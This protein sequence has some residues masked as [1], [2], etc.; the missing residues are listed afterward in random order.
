MSLGALDFGLGNT[1]GP[2]GFTDQLGIGDEIIA[3]SL[4][5]VLHDCIFIAVCTAKYRYYWH[6][7]LPLDLVNS[8]IL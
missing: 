7:Y 3:G 1:G 2:A 8:L 6:L 5:Q 4:A